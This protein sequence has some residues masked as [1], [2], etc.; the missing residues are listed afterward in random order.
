MTIT[1]VMI[2]VFPVPLLPL[3]LFVAVQRKTRRFIKRLKHQL[4]F[5]R[6]C[7]VA[8]MTRI[9]ALHS[10]VRIYQVND[11]ESSL[12]QM[13]FSALRNC[14]NIEWTGVERCKKR[15]KGEIKSKQM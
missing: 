1:P 3:H 8:T 5:T 14:L 2:D 12:P 7:F 15:R 11:A 13:G 9:G 10:G 6:N 4:R